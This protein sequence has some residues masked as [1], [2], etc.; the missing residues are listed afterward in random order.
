MGTL[1]KKKEMGEEISLF[2]TKKQIETHIFLIYNINQKW[3]IGQFYPK[4]ITKNGKNA[5][6]W[7]TMINMFAKR[8]TEKNSEIFEK[9]GVGVQ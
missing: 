2:S 7:M 1:L 9:E 4:R 8:L 3:A 6:A 5:R